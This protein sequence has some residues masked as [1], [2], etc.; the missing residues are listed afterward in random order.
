MTASIMTVLAPLA[1]IALLALRNLRG[2]KLRLERL[3]LAPALMAAGAAFLL[4]QGP[5]A[6]PLTLIGYLAAFAL[7]AA[8]GWYRGRL[9]QILVDPATHEIS[10]KGTAA[11][12]ML[13]AA[14]FLARYG[15]RVFLIPGMAMDVHAGAARITDALILFSIGVI[16]VQRLEMGLR[17]KRL[18]DEAR[19]ARANRHGPSTL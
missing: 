1:L 3:W 2:R 17:A 12:M 8:L 10:S 7:G 18:L 19:A 4:S 15:L 16:G 13:I 14:V 6:G 5:A 9:T 11:G